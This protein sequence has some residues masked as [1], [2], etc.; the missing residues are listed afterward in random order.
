MKKLNII[1]ITLSFISCSHLNTE[2]RD[3]Y[4]DTSNDY[5]IRHG[6]IPY[7][8]KEL[9]LNKIFPTASITSI[10]SGKNIYQK[11]C[12]NCHGKTGEGNGVTSLNKPKKPANLK[13]MVKDVH[14]FEIYYLISQLKGKMP[15]W[16][17]PLTQKE[18]TDVRNYILTFK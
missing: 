8:V 9:S 1:A 12:L 10:K 6:A 16:S 7:S 18:L 13:K 3:Y 11:H 5:Q 4:H 14:N 17:K 15:G 2:S